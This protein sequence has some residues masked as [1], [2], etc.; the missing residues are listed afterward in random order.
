[1]Q[2]NAQETEA[3]YPY[4][5]NTFNFGITGACNANTA[6]GIGQTV[7]GTGNDYVVVG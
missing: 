5:F 3:D 2:S 4:S 6:L 7:A 1:L